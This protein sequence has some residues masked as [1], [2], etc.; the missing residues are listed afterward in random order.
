MS[1]SKVL[2][3]TSFMEFE[4]SGTGWE[5]VLQEAWNDQTELELQRD[6]LAIHLKTALPSA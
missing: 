2:R 6:R 3:R 4:G 1:A 5:H